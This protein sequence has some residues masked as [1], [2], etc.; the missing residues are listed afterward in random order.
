MFYLVNFFYY[1]AVISYLAPIFAYRKP[2]QTLKFLKNILAYSLWG[3]LGN[4]IIIVYSYF[5]GNGH[6]AGHIFNLVQMLIL[7]NIF[8]SLGL[9]R[10]MF[11]LL[12]ILLALLF[13]LE[14]IVLKY[15]TFTNEVFHFLSLTIL[16]ALSYNGLR[17]QSEQ[18]DFQEKFAN[19]FCVIFFI[20]SVSSILLAIYEEDLRTSSLIAAF[21]VIVTNN[22]ITIFQNLGIT[23]S[24]WKLKE[25]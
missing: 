11:G 9:V 16:V 14:S 12:L 25:A 7:L 13:T 21:I 20:S 18:I 17:N 3:I 19:Y 24:L 4:I 6:P 15:W 10:N 8:R 5:F 2:F 1:A 23:Y 22:L